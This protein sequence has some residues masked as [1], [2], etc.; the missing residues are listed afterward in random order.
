[1][2][3]DNTAIKLR[4]LLKETAVFGH[5]S[6]TDIHTKNSIVWTAAHQRA[7]YQQFGGRIGRRIERGGA[8][9]LAVR[10]LQRFQH[11]LLHH[12]GRGERV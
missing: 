8:V 6:H 1:M 11:R 3:G 10:H 5:V 12:D 2:G 9:H 4:V 7:D